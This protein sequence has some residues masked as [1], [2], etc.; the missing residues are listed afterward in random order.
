MNVCVC[1]CVSF[2]L[3]LSLY[4]YAAE[5]FISFTTLVL[6]RIRESNKSVTQTDE[7]IINLVK[8]NRYMDDPHLDTHTYVARAT[9]AFCI[10]TSYDEIKKKTSF[11][12]IWHIHTQRW[13]TVSIW[14][15]CT[16]NDVCRVARVNTRSD[17]S[18][19]RDKA[20]KIIR[21]VFNDVL[22]MKKREQNKKP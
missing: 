11:L 15:N 18:F 20:T 1:M 5:L 10:H 9:H 16:K 8:R 22:E 2:S 7:Q 17:Q 12:F 14:M 13:F 3:S 6:I 4:A 19:N 21:I